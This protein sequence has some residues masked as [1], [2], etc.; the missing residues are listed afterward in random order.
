MFQGKTLSISALGNGLAE[1]NFDNKGHSVNVFNKVTVGELTAALD[2]LEAATDIKGVLVTSGKAVFIVGADVSEF[3]EAFAGDRQAVR[4]HIWPN[5]QNFNRLEALP[6]PVVV[7]IN[8]FALGGGF[9]FCLACDYRVMSTAARI[10]FP[11]VGLGLIPGWGGTVRAPRLAGFAKG[12]EAVA[13]GAQLKAD[14]ALDTGMVDAV[15]EPETLRD[16]ALAMLNKAVAGELDVQARRSQKTGPVA[17]DPTAL[18][19]AS[20]A[21]AAAAAKQFGPNYPAGDV[22]VAMMTKAAPLARDQALEAEFEAFVG[23]AQSPQ[24]RALVGNFTSDQF[25]SAVAKKYAAKATVKT[26]QAGVLGAGIMGGGIAYQNALKGI[27]SVMK[28]IAQP[29]LDL[30]M[31]EAKTLLGRQVSRGKMAQAKA[32]A[33]LASIEPT[34]DYGALASVDLIVEAVVEKEVVKKAVLAE[35]E[36]L[37]SANTLLASNTSSLSVTKLA[38]VL[39]RPENF[40]GIHFFNPVHAM[41]LVEVVRG[42]KTSDDTVARAVAYVLTIG[43]KP[44]VVKDCPGF[45]VNRTL[46]MYFG[47]FHML[48][49][50][51]ADHV[52]VDQA[53]EKWGWP[54]GPAYL[55]DVVGLDT[56]VHAGDVVANGFADR[57]LLDY[58]STTHALVEAGRFG[59]KNGKGYYKFEK[60][61]KG[62]LEKLVDS[63]VKA[64]FAPHVAAT[65]SFNDEEIVARVMIPMAT[66]MARCLEEGIAGSPQE[67]DQA[68]L[69][70]LGFPAFR[71]G[72]CR[73]M[74]ELGLAEICAMADKY[75][76]LGGMYHPTETMRAMARDGKTYY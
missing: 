37:V 30:G 63:E 44:V 20:Q 50:E 55:S 23:L 25:L 45:L 41:P 6:F 2:V 54:M 14:A 75:A 46:F 64:L 8:G 35:V 70:G 19:E 10:G 59:Q 42:E 17:V 29:A 76:H 48:M 28:D 16:Q 52:Q 74:D 49:R 73:W 5:N 72:I 24:G 38:E 57:L 7:A 40:C 61:D 31:N 66:E 1:L 47:G 43:K 22:A 69:S 33:I 9:E 12:V 26:A 32:D 65:R 71:G 11:E 3:A 60:N 39:Q 56:A 53:M 13:F 62:R 4:N 67:A 68:L 18:A 21:L 58:K 36:Q 15:A 51:G 34:L 27:P